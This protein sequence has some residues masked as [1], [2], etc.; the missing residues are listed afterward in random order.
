MRLHCVREN[1]VRD[2]RRIGFTLTELLVVIAI[3]GILSSLIMSAVH[4]SKR[5]GEQ[6][7]CLS[8]LRQIGMALSVYVE[9]TEQYPD[10]MNM[11]SLG[12][13][14]KPTI[15]DALKD[16]VGGA[17]QVFKCL[18]DK[19][20][21]Y[22]KERSSYEWSVMLNAQS[23]NPKTMFGNNIDPKTF[24]VLWDFENFHGPKGAVGSYN[25]LFLDNRTRSF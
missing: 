1:A 11:P 18:G 4:D 15:S 7:H 14:D 13:S 6:A 8:N 22:D 3:I 2:V 25:I 5:K 21:F 9:R 24:R 19:T 17:V 16:D 12:L 23:K 10:C 20:G